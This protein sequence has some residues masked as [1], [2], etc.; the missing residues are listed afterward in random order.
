M[1]LMLPI[2]K[3]IDP[4]GDV[5]RLSVYTKLRGFAAVAALREAGRGPRDRGRRGGGGL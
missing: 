5:Q 3:R 2:F 1:A 4:E